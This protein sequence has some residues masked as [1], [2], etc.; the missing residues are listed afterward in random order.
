MGESLYTKYRPQN[1]GEV[2]GQ[3][4]CIEALQ[5]L[6]AKGNTHSFL[7]TGPYG[8]GKTSIGRLIAQ[9]V[10][11]D[12]QF[13]F[14]EVNA[15]NDRG[16]DTIRGIASNV[17]SPPLSGKAL[18]YLIDEAHR[19]T[20]DASEALLKPMED[21]PEWAY[22]IL[23]TSEPTKIPAGLKQRCT[24]FPVT[25]LKSFDIMKVL[26]KVNTEEELDVPREILNKVA[27]LA[28]GSP[29]QALVLLEQV[30]VLDSPDKMTELLSAFYGQEEKV[31]HFCQ[32]LLKKDFGEAKKALTGLSEDAEAIRRGVLGY[33]GKVIENGNNTAKA[34]MAA[35]IFMD[36][37]QHQYMGKPALIWS[38]WM[39]CREG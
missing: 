10:G 20:K 38:T 22:F 23:A 3:E 14:I 12:M 36:F 16:I 2:I 17:K 1:W 28:E 26:K 25:Y 7:L 18:V 29:R 6:L 27:E 34:D 21:C 30:S 24:H 8:C 19:I 9:E 37:A 39:V 32:A 15:G 31:G 13:G 11:A 4:V 5:A 33:M 35:S